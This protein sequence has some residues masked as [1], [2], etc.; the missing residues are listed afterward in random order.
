MRR[1]NGVDE[2]DDF[3]KKADSC[4]DENVPTGFQKLDAAIGGGLGSGLTILCGPDEMYKN[5]LLEQIATNISGSGREV[6]FIT[7]STRKVIAA[8]AISRQSYLQAGEDGAF[9]A[10]ELQTEK[11]IKHL[12]CAQECI[13]QDSCRIVS[14]QWARLSFLYNKGKSW[15]VSEL[16]EYVQ[17]EWLDC[18]YQSPVIFVDHQ[19]MAF[20]DDIENARQFPLTLKSLSA[21]LQTP[22]IMISSQ[23]IQ[24]I[25]SADKI[26]NLQP[27]SG[28]EVHSDPEEKQRKN[29]EIKVVKNKEGESGIKIPMD[30]YEQFAYFME[31]DWKEKGKNK[32]GR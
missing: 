10:A 19:L 5:T 4:W 11:I 30:Y 13:Y 2:I 1:L 12:N 23:D 15:A 6:L 28:G 31:S 26:L 22:V 20:T 7:N 29:M 3:S 21:R 9:T 24:N 8:K 14:T 16:E 27:A 25:S 18:D 32:N 17:R